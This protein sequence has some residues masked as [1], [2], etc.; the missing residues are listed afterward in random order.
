MLQLPLPM[1]WLPLLCVLLSKVNY[2]QEVITGDNLS[3]SLEMFEL[4]GFYEENRLFFE[5]IRHSDE[6]ICDLKSAI[7]SVELEHALRTNGEKYSKYNQHLF[8][9][10]YHRRGIS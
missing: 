10:K 5:H 4:S 8:A 1:L 3:D 6:V 9:H 2:V 7:Q